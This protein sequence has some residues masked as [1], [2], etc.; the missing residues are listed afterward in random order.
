VISAHV[1]DTL[2]DAATTLSDKG[3]GA[4]IVLDDTERLAGILSERDLVRELARRGT[5]SL[6]V[7]VADVMTP[8]VVTC[9]PDDT[10]EELMTL[11]TNGRFRHVPVLEDNRVIGVISI[12]D[13]VKRRI[14]DAEHEAREMRAYIATG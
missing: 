11:M 13:V 7:R 9:G 3:I 2:A 8:R 12:G 14:A 6:S 1:S 5:E 10:I 4:V